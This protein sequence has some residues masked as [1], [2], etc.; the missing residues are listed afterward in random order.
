[1]KVAAIKDMG[2]KDIPQFDLTAVFAAMVN[3]VAHHDYAI[4]GSKIRLKLF[5]DRLEIYSPGSIPNTMTVDSLI[6]RQ[7]ARNETLTRFVA[8]KPPVSLH[9]AA[10][11]QG[12]KATLTPR[13]A[14]CYPINPEATVVC[15]DGI[16]YQV[17]KRFADYAKAL[18]QCFGKLGEVVIPLAFVPQFLTTV[19]GAVENIGVVQ[20]DESM[21]T[22]F[23]R[24]QLEMA[25]LSPS[26]S[27][28]AN[29]PSILSPSDLSPRPL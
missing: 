28:T 18:H 13:G 24:E 16:L 26:S 12:V 14:S 11:E 27:G 23:Y 8:G 7:S 17:E 6:Y 19:A 9:V 1:M 25:S 15:H 2:R 5:A 4:Y 22:H 3:A 21:L 10:Y 29:T 20:L